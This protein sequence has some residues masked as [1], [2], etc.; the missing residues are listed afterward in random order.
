[1]KT[2][3]A[4]VAIFM[5]A[6][7]LI[8]CDDDLDTP[9][10]QSIGDI[11]VRIVKVDNEVRYA[12]VLYNYS[13]FSI[14]EINVEGPTDSNLSYELT[15][16]DSDTG[17]RW[18]PSEDDYTTEDITNGIYTFQVTA[19]DETVFT[20]VDKLLDTRINPVE[21]TNFVYDEDMH[22]FELDWKDIEDADTY[23][24]KIMDSKDGK[25]L[26]VSNRLYTSNHNFN[27]SSNKWTSFE[28]VDGTTY[29]IGVYAY[30]FETAQASS[31]YDINCESVEFQDFEW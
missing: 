22:S 1:M 14:K 30:K 2:I 10:T 26:Y 25:Y 15:S 23:V 13:N 20:T 4:I 7:V 3:R 18:L 28:K 21:I 8:S 31:G 29:V 6:T 9:S 16:Y 12:P 27:I 5:C 19:S 24:V 17:F 11:F